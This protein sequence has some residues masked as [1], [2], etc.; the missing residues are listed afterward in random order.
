MIVGKSLKLPRIV[1]VSQTHL[2]VLALVFKDVLQI[3]PVEIRKLL[4][5]S[6]E[7]SKR[8]RKS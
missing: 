6:P 2:K 3:L 5:T 8:K 7:K 1:E 4:A